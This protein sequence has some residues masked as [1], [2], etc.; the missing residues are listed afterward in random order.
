M[1]AVTGNTFY[2]EFEVRLMEWIQQILGDKGAG[3]VS[4]FSALGEEYFLILLIAFLYWCYDK[5]IGEKVGSI[6]VLGVII[7]PLIKNIFWRRRP[8]FDHKSIECYRPLDTEH[9]LFDISAQ[10]LSFPSGHSTNAAAAF[11]SIAMIVRKKWATILC[12]IIILLIGF[13]RVAVGVHYPTDV[14]VGWISGFLCIWF[15]VFCRNKIPEEKTWI[16]YLVI[17]LI[18]CLGLL[19][20]K[21]TDYFTCLGL[22]G[23]I[24]GAFEFEKRF[25]HFE[26]T[27]NPLS[28]VLRIFFGVAIYLVLNT[29][30]KLPFSA[31]FLDSG[32][33]I[34]GIV[35]S[36]RYLIVSF[37]TVGVYPYTFRIHKHIFS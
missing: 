21:T 9:D 23:G 25:V 6:L 13:S 15:I 16:L 2:F 8:Y 36:L 17:F 33:L 24:Y 3:I 10:G 14:I 35:R 30:L 37:I 11:G 1:D 29:L 18:S 4:H 26:N 28:C 32:T 27:R 20:C 34:A 12:G 5:R 31:E 7:N 19:Y 22:V